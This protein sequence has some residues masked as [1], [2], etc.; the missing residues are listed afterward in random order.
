[1]SDPTPVS[2]KTDET[3]LFIEWSNG[4]SD[5]IPFG[6]LRDCCPC[7]TCKVEREQKIKREPESNLLPVLSV[8]ETQPLRLSAMQPTGNYAYS[9]HFTDGHNSGI[10][11][12]ELLFRLGEELQRI[13]RERT[14]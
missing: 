11:T 10:Y 4:R 7:A 5:R 8:A 14:K 2:L 3:A 1:M 6:V 13:E 9:I 12:L